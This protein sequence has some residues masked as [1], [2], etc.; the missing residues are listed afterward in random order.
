MT[1]NS[2]RGVDCEEFFNNLVTQIAEYQSDTQPFIIC[3]DFYTRCADIPDHIQGVDD[4]PP[5]D[6]IDWSVNNYGDPFKH[7]F[8]TSVLLYC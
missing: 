8:L 4:L 3:G 1:C 2:T 7:H 6:V 5:R